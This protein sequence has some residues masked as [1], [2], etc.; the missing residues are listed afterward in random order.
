MPLPQ[1]VIEQLGREPPK[2]PGWSG[3]LLMFSGLIFFLS[4]FIYLGLVFGYKT[5][6]NSEVRKLDDQVQ[7]FSQQI[8]L[9][10]QVK[11]INFYSQLVNIK[12][13][14][15]KHVYGSSIFSWL[16]KNTQFNVYYR[17][18]GLDTSASSL[19]LSGSAKTMDDVIQ[20]I[21]IFQSRP[22]IGKVSVSSVSFSEGAWIFDVSIIFDPD[23]F[24]NPN[25]K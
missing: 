8:P 1:K 6:L 21:A 18:F 10:E 9:E 2:T 3:R 5:Y 20:Q 15:A 11:I 23:F 4:L 25:N 13:L 16:E 12:S 19:H 17:D 22:E 14:L 7:K 24:H